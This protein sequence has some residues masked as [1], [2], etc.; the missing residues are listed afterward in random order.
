MLG[1]GLVGRR[2]Q[3]YTF[4]PFDSNSN[5]NICVMGQSG[6]GKSVLMQE[7]VVS[8]LGIGDRV[9][10]LDVGRSFQKLGQI[11]KAQFIQITQKEHFSL[12]PF[13]HLVTQSGDEAIDRDNMVMLKQVITSM[14]SPSG[15]LDELESSFLSMAL[16]AVIEEKANKA[17]VT[18]IAHWFSQH[19]DQRV[20]D[21]GTRL[22]SFTK[23]GSYGKFF[24]GCAT[25]NFSNRLIIAEFE[26]IKQSKELSAVILQIL[27]VNI[28]N[29]MYR[30]DRKTKFA[31]IVD[32]AWEFLAGK[33]G[34][35]LIE[36]AARQARK[37]GGLLVV[38]S[39]NAED[40][41]K[42]LAAKAAFNNSA[43]KF[44]LSQSNEAFKAFEKEE[45]ITSPA[46]LSLLKTV[47]MNP[48]KYGETLIVSD[49]GYAI[50]RLLL[51]PYSQL[52]YS[53]KADEFSAV[54]GL[55]K[56]GVPVK[57]AIDRL[58]EERKKR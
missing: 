54:E 47:K 34:E 43:W 14:I 24:T 20:K 26:D 19:S 32:E 23:Q 58:L 55:V 6:A 42:S 9:V 18:D 27:I 13:S 49:A 12:N 52:L 30:S 8:L 53:T 38:G 5:Y 48:K 50:G 21:M 17:E 37:Y 56:Q 7:L 35:M 31:I 22:Y 33:A 4:S 44:Y 25:L 45:L 46:M 41:H 16:N 2:G 11:L 28:L 1:C 57:E 39:Q 36:A 29:M 10:V 51:D 3:L 40:F 15:M